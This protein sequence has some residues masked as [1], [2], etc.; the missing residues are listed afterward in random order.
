MFHRLLFDDWVVIFP[1]VAFI[2]AVSVYV[3]LTWRALKMRPAQ[4][5]H[6]ENLPFN[7]EPIR[8]ASEHDDSE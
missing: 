3:T 1:L 2:T 5:N 8:P 6:F 7:D 4:L